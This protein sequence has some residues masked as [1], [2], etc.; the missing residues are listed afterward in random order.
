MRETGLSL[1][2]LSRLENDNG[3]PNPDTVVKLA[4]ALDAD[5]ERML[6]L[7]KCLPREILDR[8]ARRAVGEA[9]PYRRTAGNQPE[10]PAF[11]NALIEDI[12][13]TLRSAV[14]QNFG[15]SDRDVEGFFS[16]LQRVARMSTSEREV[17]LRFLTHA[18]EEGGSGPS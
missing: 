13:P 17:V 12:D 2:H 11:A 15:L 7:A 10:D 8:L 16:I 14:A 6:E 4:L 18:T 5:L 1:S 9:Q 3:L